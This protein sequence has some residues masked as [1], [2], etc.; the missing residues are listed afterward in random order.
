MQPGVES[1][2]HAG[3]Y[4]FFQPV[5]CRLPD[6]M[7]ECE[8]G[9]VGLIPDLKGIAPVDE[10]GRP[11]AHDD[12]Q[13]GRAGESGQPGQSFGICGHKFTEMFVRAGNDEA[14][15]FQFT[16]P[17]PQPGNPVA[18]RFAGRRFQFTT[19]GQQGLTG[20]CVGGRCDQINPTVGRPGNRGGCRPCYRLAK[21]FSRQAAAGA[22]MEVTNAGL[23]L[24]VG[25]GLS[26]IGDAI[27]IM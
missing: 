25:H 20:G 13:T 16:Q 11:V 23:A 15:Q 22:G 6:Q 3:L 2:P 5:G 19:Q 14:V 8:D 10:Q 7:A 27:Q 12:R 24:V 4:L 1:D 9:F 26:G 21:G 18:A 17:G